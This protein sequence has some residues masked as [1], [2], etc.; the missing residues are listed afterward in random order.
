MYTAFTFNN[1]HL[2]STFQSIN[3]NP[4]SKSHTSTREAASQ[5]HHQHIPY[6]IL[7]YTYPTYT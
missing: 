6:S 4:S 7:S 1:T 2:T 5:Q 3:Q